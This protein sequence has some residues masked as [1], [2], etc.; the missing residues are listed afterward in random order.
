[1]ASGRRIR[2]AVVAK[3]REAQQRHS[4]LPVDEGN[5]AT[6]SLLFYLVYQAHAGGL[7]HAPLDRRPQSTDN[8]ENPE[9]IK[10]GHGSSYQG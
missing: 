7:K 1:M 3:D 8:E 6:V 4:L 2:W 5:D 9:K 10:D